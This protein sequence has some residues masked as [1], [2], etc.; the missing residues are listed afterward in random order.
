M[1]RNA[2]P[3]KRNTSK[4][5]FTDS[6]T[7]LHPNHNYSSYFSYDYAA[8]GY[9]N[10]TRIDSIH[11]T[12]FGYPMNAEIKNNTGHRVVCNSERVD[13]P[14]QQVLCSYLYCYQ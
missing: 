10:Q 7:L 14:Y 11:Y 5:Q 9:N 2:P 6:R 4:G 1:I 8:G 12:A 13:V 3:R